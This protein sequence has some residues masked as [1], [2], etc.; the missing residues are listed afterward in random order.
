MTSSRK[1]LRKHKY[2]KITENRLRV[3]IILAT[4]V[5]AVLA[6][7]LKVELP[8]VWTFLTVVVTATLGKVTAS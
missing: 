8:A 7:T 4:L 3:I 1:G 5:V 6:I 2:T